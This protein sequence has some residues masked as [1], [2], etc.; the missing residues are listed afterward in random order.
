MLLKMNKSSLLT[1]A[2]SA[3]LAATSALAQWTLVND[4]ESGEVPSSYTMQTT[5]SSA[6]MKIIDDAGEVTGNHAFYVESGDLGLGFADTR[7]TIPMPET[8]GPG[9]VATIYARYYQYGYSN[10]F[11][12][13]ST[14]QP[15]LTGWSDLNAVYRFNQL[16]NRI[17]DMYDSTG[18]D[19]TSPEYYI[20][21]EIWY[22]LWVVLDYDNS[23]YETW[24]KGPDDASPVQLTSMN[25]SSG[26]FGFRH[27][28]ASA[29]QEIHSIVVASNSGGTADPNLGDVWVIDD[30]YFTMGDQAGV[31]PSSTPTAMTW[32]GIEA[33]EN[34]WLTTG[35]WIGWINIQNKPWVFSYAFNGFV[36]A[37]D[38]GADVAGSWIYTVNNNAPGSL[39]FSTTGTTWGGLEANGDGWLNTGNWMGW[40]NIQNKPW[41]FSYSLNGFVY[42][43]DPGA[44][45]AGAWIYTVDGN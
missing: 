5:S 18:Y 14:D 24:I 38:P 28:A 20:D 12:L 34:G 3:S 7:V 13:G 42:A 17:V 19:L 36:Y 35:K 41:I 23:T 22:D 1:I 32:G 25:N 40:I 27:N 37:P 11:I 8:V 33:D 9:E 2:A 29:S 4:F 10:L 44:D 26:S 30:I 21:D 39:T 43:P 16:D 31:M 45:V 6:S 15:A